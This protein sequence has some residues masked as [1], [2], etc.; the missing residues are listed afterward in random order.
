[1]LYIL[2]LARAPN[3]TAAPDPMPHLPWLLRWEEIDPDNIWIFLEDMELTSSTL[4]IGMSPRGSRMFS[5]LRDKSSIRIP[6]ASPSQSTSLSPSLSPS[7]YPSPSTTPSP[8]PSPSPSQSPSPS[9][10]PSPSPS[11]SPTLSPSPSTYPSPSPYPSLSTSTSPLSSLLSP[12]SFLSSSPTGKPN[13]DRGDSS[14]LI[15]SRPH[16]ASSTF[17]YS[18]SEVNTG[19]QL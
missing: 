2:L 11:P 12:F 19:P 18:Y 16:W 15:Q 14:S 17:T 13:L 9:T 1:M 3:R 8:S 7:P 10:S 5:T 4:R 6:R